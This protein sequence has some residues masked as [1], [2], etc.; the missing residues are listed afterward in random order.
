MSKNNIN[1]PYNC[2]KC[3][4]LAA[5]ID[6]QKEK[7]P[8]Y[9]NGPVP[10]FFS[11]DPKLMVIG[12]APGL[13]GANQTGRPFTGDWAGDLLYAAMKEYGFA[14]G[15]YDKVADDGLELV[16]AV[17]TNAVRCVPPQNKPVGAEINTCREHFLKPQLNALPELKVMLCLG[18]I[19]HDSTARA[20]GLK[21]STHKFGHGTEYADW[22]GRTLLSSYHCSRYN[23]NTK[24]LTEEMF[25]DIFARAR[26][27]C[28][29]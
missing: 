6:E 25:F 28:D 1:A 29:K 13:H 27:L 18:K 8:T 10:N 20:L 4:R 2:R 9:F 7:L 15:E 5:F 12:L 17:I 23:T 14:K 11:P 24:R 21:L 3:P 19:S 22:S 26:E 16:N